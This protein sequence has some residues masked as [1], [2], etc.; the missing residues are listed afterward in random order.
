MPAQV[1]HARARMALEAVERRNHATAEELKAD[2]DRRSGRAI[3]N[4]LSQVAPASHEVV[5]EMSE[6]LNQQ[7]N[8]LFRDPQSRGWFRL[9]SHMDDDKSGRISYNEFVGRCISV[10]ELLVCC[11][12]IA[13]KLA[14]AHTRAFR[15]L[16]HVRV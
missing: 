9:F 6:R 8:V 2:I 1:T 3:A 4:A 10:D 12:S 14:C 11:V 7:M 5:I 16:T 15:V 13:R